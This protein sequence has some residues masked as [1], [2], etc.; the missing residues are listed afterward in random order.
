M[1]LESDCF[2]FPSWL[3]SFDFVLAGVDYWI[4]NR[5]VTAR[6]VSNEDCLLQGTQLK[7]PGEGPQNGVDLTQRLCRMSA[8]RFLLDDQPSCKGPTIVFRPSA[9]WT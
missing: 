2:V 4:A 7:E 1:G 8:G 6:I 3:G 9:L 5:S